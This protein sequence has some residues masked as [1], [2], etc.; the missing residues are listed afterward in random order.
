MKEKKNGKQKEIFL[1]TNRLV[2]EVFPISKQQVIGRKKQLKFPVT[3][4]SCLGRRSK[5]TI[6]QLFPFKVVLRPFPV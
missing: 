4:D 6:L 3:K 1:R 2:F 5:L